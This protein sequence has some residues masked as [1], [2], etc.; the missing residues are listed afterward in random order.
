MVEQGYR[1]WIS[2]TN[3]SG[4]LLGRPVELVLIDDKSS[5]AL[6]ADGY[7]HLIEVESVDLLLSPY[8]TPNAVAAARV[9]DAH[10]MVMIASS[11]ASTTVWEQ[12][13]QQLFGMYATA[14][15]YF[16]G[17]LDLMARHGLT[18]ISVAH[19]ENDFNI[20]VAEGIVSWAS[21]FGITVIDRLSFDRKTVD[22]AALLARL[23]RGKPDAL[24]L[25]AY[26]DVGH[27]LLRELERQGYR[28]PVLGMPIAPVHPRFYEEVGEYA[29]GVFAPS[30][31]EPD[32]RIPFPGS[33]DFVTEF[34]EYAGVKPSYHAASAYAS[35]EILE[36]A[37][38]SVGG[39]RQEE[40]G[41]YIAS[42]DSVTIIGR[43]KTDR[44]GRQIGHN[45][46]LIQWQ[47][48]TK[49]IVYPRS[50]STAPARF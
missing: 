11:S 18:T 48:G 30:Q 37:V 8:G 24:V 29:E 38:E 31:W 2:E 12:G 34:F 3:A 10:G 19:E 26:P 17:L 6:S 15:R 40:I 28:P 39:I 9:A 46:M 27:S 20:D 43:F 22:E 16:I 45:S 36:M 13:F 5:P 50:I 35:C 1:L 49:E 4:G 41:R 21:S 44:T 42:L 32:E 7:R 14:D 23:R 47:N 33:R 25:S